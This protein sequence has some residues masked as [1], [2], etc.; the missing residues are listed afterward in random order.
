MAVM[1]TAAIGIFALGALWFVL[2]A[3]AFYVQ[4][5]QVGWKQMQR[6]MR[7]MVYIIGIMSGGTVH[8]FLALLAHA[9]LGRSAGR[10]FGHNLCVQFYSWLGPLCWGAYTFEGA[11]NLPP[12]DEGCIYV[13]NHTSAVDFSV[14]FAMPGAAHVV[15]VAKSSLLFL[16]GLG[17]MTKLNGG[18]FVKRGKS[19][20]VKSLVE[21]GQA[22]LREG[23]SVGVFPQGTR[24]VPAPGKPLLAFRKGGFVLADASKAK[25]VPVTI[26]YPSDFM[27]AEPSWAGL[28]VI[29]HPPITP[30]GDGDVEGL[31]KQVEAVVTAPIIKATG[32][33][34]S[35]PNSDGDASVEID[36]KKTK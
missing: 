24:K 26:L 1:A 19:G 4:E 2:A 12:P 14:F 21:I 29:F 22:R 6:R 18:I 34:P 36:A 25:I 11:A 7:L 17:A 10:K 23:I 16:P 8:Q 9:V 5:C 30:K 27:S 32:A 33:L 35:T 20:G 15:A 31:M 13:S 3:A 28:K